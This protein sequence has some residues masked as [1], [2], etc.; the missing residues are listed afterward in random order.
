MSK[1]L[2]NSG[3]CT[4]STSHPFSER[5]FPA[6]SISFTVAGGSSMPSI[7]FTRAAFNLS[8]ILPSNGTS[9]EF[10]SSTCLP[11]KIESPALISSIFLAIGPSVKKGA[12][13]PIFSI[14]PL[15][16]PGTLPT[17]GLI[18]LIPQQ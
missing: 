8:G 18:E 15:C 6:S 12:I 7:S 9:T 11:A 5:I 14:A 2:S 1:T 4:S 3:A 13:K 16:T 17:V 10:G